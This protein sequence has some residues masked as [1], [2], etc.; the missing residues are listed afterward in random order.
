MLRARYVSI[1]TSRPSHRTN[2]Q[3]LTLVSAV[4]VPAN[5]D[6]PDAKCGNVLCRVFTKLLTGI[7][8]AKAS[9]KSVGNRVKCFCVKCFKHFAGHAHSMRPAEALRLP[10]GTVVLPTH[11][12][13]R[14]QGGKPH[15][16]GHHHKG[17]VHRMAHVM[18]ATVKLAFVPILIGVAFGMAAS[19]IG[20]LVG[21]LVVF[22]WM[23]YRKTDAQ[24]VY[25][26]LEGDEK[27]VPPPYEDVPA[28]EAVTEK[29]V[30]ARA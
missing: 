1:L 5:P 25:E 17:F 26:P 22:L 27:E 24:G 6:S 13:F 4:A 18:W 8:K 20:M 19:A 2:N 7:N 21:Q 3:Q 30:E 14:P 15:H 12:K 29:E 16:H 28:A 9:A 11:H 23:R 10:D